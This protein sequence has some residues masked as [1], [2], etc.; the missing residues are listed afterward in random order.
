MHVSIITCY[1]TG[2]YV[3]IWLVTIYYIHYLHTYTLAYLSW[4]HPIF[5]FTLISLLNFFCY[6]IC[7]FASEPILWWKEWKGRNKE[8]IKQRRNIIKC[9]D[10]WTNCKYVQHFDAKNPLAHLYNIKTLSDKVIFGAEL[11]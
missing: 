4:V 10:T 5:F 9:F 2:F 8:E 7:V 6:F 3:S 11:Q 1:I